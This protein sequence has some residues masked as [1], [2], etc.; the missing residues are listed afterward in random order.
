MNIYS[1]FIPNKTKPFRSQPSW[2]ITDKVKTVLRGKNRVYR[3]F[4][5][6][7]RPIGKLEGIQQMT[8]EGLNPIEDTKRNYFLKAG[9]TLAN[10]RTSD[11]SY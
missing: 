10:P 2:K 1:N 4:A 9:S 3:K 5:K 6:N 7:G 8:S 11:K